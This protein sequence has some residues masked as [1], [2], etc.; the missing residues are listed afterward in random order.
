MPGFLPEVFVQEYDD[1]RL[2]HLLFTGLI[3]RQVSRPTQRFEDVS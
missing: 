2:W 1:V 3:L